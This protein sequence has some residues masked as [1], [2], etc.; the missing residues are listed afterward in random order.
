MLTEKVLNEDVF[1]IEESSPERHAFNPADVKG[2]D[3]TVAAEEMPHGYLTSF[4]FVGAIL[5]IGVAMACGQGGFSLIAPVLPQI[6]Q[7]IGP[8]SGLTW[9][10]LCYLL[11]T[12]I[13]LL[14]VGRVTDYLRSAMVVHLSKCHRRVRNRAECPSFDCRTDRIEVV[15]GELVPIRY[16]FAAIAVVFIFIIPVSAVGPAVSYAFIFN[17]KA[18][19]RGIFYIL[20]ALNKLSTILFY[21]FYHPPSFA[22]KHDTARKWEFVKNFDYI[23]M[24]LA[25]SALL[26][27]LMGLSWG[28]VLHPWK[29]AHVISTIV[30][31][32]FLLVAFFVYEAYADLKEPLVPLSLYRNRGWVATTLLWGTGSALH[33]ANAILWPAMV[34]VLYAPGHGWVRNGFLASVP[35][36]AI[37][38]GEFTSPLFKKYTNVQLRILFPIV[39]VLLACV[40]TSNPDSVVRSTI[41]IFLASYFIGWCE[42]INSTVSTI[43]IDYQREIRTA[44]GTGGATRQLFSVI[45]VPPALLKAGLPASSIPAFILAVSVDPSA[46]FRSISGATPAIAR[47]GARAYQEASA[48][49]YGTVFLTTISLSVVSMIIT[50]WAPNVNQLLT[51]NVNVPIPGRNSDK[52][53]GVRTDIEAVE[54]KV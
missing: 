38:L 53:V 48:A 13:G 37:V 24:V 18:G 42:M 36:A 33:Y 15:V 45:G 49:A 8:D 54:Q 4:R 50:I 52:V 19:W 26:L 3:F 1:H 16:R 9:V 11:I 35:G 20:I 14:I 7:D 47:A 31:G 25:I 17:T 22:M 23:G 10:A 21:V 43:S 34:S 27:L 2:R 5:V 51:R 32:F 30:I 12:S 41:I 44:V 40:A 6:N 28:G 29:S 39:G 46:N